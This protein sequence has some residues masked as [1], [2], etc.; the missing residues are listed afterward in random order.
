MYDFHYNYIIEKF[1][2]ARLLFTDTDSL[3]YWI[4]TEKDLYEEIK[5]QFGH[6]KNFS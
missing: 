1:P 4:E 6:R 2:S 3:C 5:V